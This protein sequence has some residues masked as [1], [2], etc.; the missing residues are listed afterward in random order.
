[1]TQIAERQS[2]TVHFS[3][4]DEFGM[5]LMEIAQEHLTCSNDPVKAL[6]TI[7]DSLIGC[8]TDIAVKILKGELVLPVDM[9]TRQVICTE[10][11]DGVHDDFPRIDP[12]DFLNRRAEDIVKHGNY[13]L[14]GLKELQNRIKKGNGF[15]PVDFHYEDIFKFVAGDKKVLLEELRDNREIDA[16]A[17]LFEGTKKFVEQTLKTK[18]TMEWVAQTF[19]EF[20]ESR[21]KGGNKNYETYMQLRG[22]VDGMLADISYDLKQTTELQ[23][24]L[25]APT[26]DVRAYI[27][28]AQQIDATLSTEI[29]PVDIMSNWSA[30]WLAPDGDFYGLNGEIANMLHIQIADALI[31]KGVIPADT[32]NPDSWLEERG[33]VKIHGNYINFG[34]CNNFRLGRKNVDMTNVQIKKIYEYISLCHN[35]IMQLGWKQQTVTAPQW[36][37][38]ADNLEVM[39]KE[40]FEY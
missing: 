30:G 9:P 1:M 6:R 39:Y 40:Y 27:E 4:G 38:L 17:S 26:D 21:V 13:I 10:R 22:D 7:T 2:S 29:K 31:E 12:V 28:A 36:Q 5:R 32:L 18:F 33:W 11:I 23:F 34:G 35:R 14:E 15:F 19:D 25:D 20:L 16:I 24:S 3:I 8:P 37:L